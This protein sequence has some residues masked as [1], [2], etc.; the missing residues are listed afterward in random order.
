MPRTLR[1][2][3]AALVL[4]AVVGCG[5]PPEGTVSGTVSADG[6]PLKDGLIR[7]EPTAPDAKPVDAIITDGKYTA[8]LAPGDTKVT[9]RANKVVGQTK[10]Y[11]PDGPSVDKTVEMIDPAFND[12]TTL[13]YTVTAGDQ[14]K[15]WEVKKR[16]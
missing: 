1:A 10:M 16:K 9:I 15:D 7:F 6:E 8:K 3:T 12:S 13:R 14:K 11:G 5:G 4:A 2:A